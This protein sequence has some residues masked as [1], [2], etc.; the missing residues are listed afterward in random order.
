MAQKTM[1][2][3]AALEELKNGKQIAREH[4]G[5]T[6]ICQSVAHSPFK[7]ERPKPYISEHIHGEF[8][9]RW[10]PSSEDILAEDWIILGERPKTEATEQLFDCRIQCVRCREI[11]EQEDNIEKPRPWFKSKV[12]LDHAYC[13]HCESYQPVFQHKYPSGTDYETW[14]QR[15]NEFDGFKD[16]DI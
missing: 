1:S 5:K 10:S 8:I 9:F 16:I 7:G 14:E 13:R 6:Y 11:I 2:F 12:R 15:F 3:S 4:W